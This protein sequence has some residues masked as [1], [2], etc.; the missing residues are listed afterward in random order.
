MDHLKYVCRTFF[1]TFKSLYMN[2]GPKPS[3]LIAPCRLQSLG[4]RI[5]DVD[6]LGQ[7]FPNL[8][9]YRADDTHVRPTNMGLTVG[10]MGPGHVG[11]PSGPHHVPVSGSQHFVGLTKPII[12][13][14][15]YSVFLK[16][17][18]S[19]RCGFQLWAHM[20]P[21]LGQ[22]IYGPCQTHYMWD[23]LIIF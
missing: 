20:D 6:C 14:T 18:I 10:S 7:P 2:L 22:T 4:C 11:R 8:S 23:P 5:G 17:T 13:G 16:K 12:R 1:T 9:K 21:Q 19:Q 3:E 15:H